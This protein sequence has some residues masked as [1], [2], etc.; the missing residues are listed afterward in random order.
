MNKKIEITNDH[1]GI[2]D[3]FFEDSLIDFYINH[4]QNLEKNGLTFNRKPNSFSHHID[5]QSCALIKDSF[6]KEIPIPYVM[7][8]FV[9]IFFE[10]CYSKYLEEYSILNEYD[11]HGILDAKIQKTTPGKGYHLWHSENKSMRFRNRICVFS[12][13]LNTVSD[14]GETEFLYQKKR[15]NPIKNRLLIW[16]AT[17]THLH[18][19]NP[20]LSGD[21]YLLTGWVEYII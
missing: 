5:D 11:K 9:Q 15:F 10:E 2:F 4:F 7:K 6:Y 21:K 19:G 16:P 17:Y 14:G 12:L 8:E 1:I 18:R 13:Y 20:P 3:N